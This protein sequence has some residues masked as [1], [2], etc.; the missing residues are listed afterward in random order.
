MSR[1]LVIV[2]PPA[3]DGGPDAGAAR[4]F[5][6]TAGQGITY[7]AG[8]W[9]HGMTVLDRGAEFAVVMWR[10]GTAADEEFVTLPG[11]LV[12]GVPS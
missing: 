5:V 8:T 7:R 9:H 3:R 4:A 10:D 2:A 11:E 6:A 1:Y 12:I